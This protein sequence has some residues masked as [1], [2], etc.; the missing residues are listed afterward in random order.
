LDTVFLGTI[1]RNQIENL[2]QNLKKWI[3]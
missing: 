3:L 2:K 1:A